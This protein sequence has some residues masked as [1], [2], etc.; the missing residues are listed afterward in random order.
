MTS[1]EKEW[2]DRAVRQMAPNRFF[3]FLYGDPSQWHEWLS[4]RHGICMRR[5]VDGK[6]EFREMDDKERASWSLTDAW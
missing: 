1:C 3:K 2:R 5:I 6:S 4:F